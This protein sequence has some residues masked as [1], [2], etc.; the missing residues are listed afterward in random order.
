MKSNGT[1][2]RSNKEWGKGRKAEDKAR[3]ARGRGKR[4]AIA[5]QKG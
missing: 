1:L 3:G 2:T 5:D 4:E